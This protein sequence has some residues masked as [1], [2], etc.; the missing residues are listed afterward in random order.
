M[1][2]SVTVTNTGTRAG[3]DVVQ[4]YVTLPDAAAAEPRRLVGF[5]KVSLAAKKSTRIELRVPVAE[6][7]V[8]KSGR[9]TLVPGSCT[10]AVARS[11]RD[12]TAQRTV[13]VG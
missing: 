5:R 4:L 9:W 3:T 13:T 8:W 11:S 12:V 6:L 2:V 7:R 10:F 1:T